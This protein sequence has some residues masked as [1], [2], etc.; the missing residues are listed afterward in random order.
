MINAKPSKARDAITILSEAAQS[1]QSIVSLAEAVERAAATITQALQGGG[2]IFFCGNGGSAADA[3]HLAG[4]FLGRFLLE[5]AP[6]SAIALPANAAA[7]TAIGN[8]Y[9]FEEVFAR[10]LQGL[11]R[12]GDVLIGIS[13]SGRSAN[14]LKAMKVARGMGIYSIGLTGAKESPMDAAADLILRA[15]ADSTPRIQEMHIVVGH[16]LCEL[17]EARLI[18]NE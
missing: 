7:M 14:V 3:E 8:D 16:T 15:P 12:T 17:V 13:T 2:K 11:G 10:Q 5:R 6:W 1:L 4:E 9:G 18:R